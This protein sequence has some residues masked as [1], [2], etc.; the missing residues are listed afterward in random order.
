[1][2]YN[3]GGLKNLVKFIG[4]LVCW[5][6]FNVNK[7]IWWD[8]AIF[9]QSKSPVKLLENGVKYVPVET[10]EKGVKYVQSSGVFIIDF[11]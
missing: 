8:P 1:M 3:I 7:L 5:S 9:A 4:K 11:F 10:L 2:F 6:N